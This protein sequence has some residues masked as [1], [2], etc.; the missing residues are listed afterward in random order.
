LSRLNTSLAGVYGVINNADA[1]PTTQ[2]AAAAADALQALATTVAA[3][4]MLKDEQ[5]PALNKQ[6]EAAKL[7]P[8]NLR[9]QI[10]PSVLNPYDEGEEP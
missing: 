2:G 4:N 3:F 10:I 5:L 7:P 1:A 9:A 6:L 8:L